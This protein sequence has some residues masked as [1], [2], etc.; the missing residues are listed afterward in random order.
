MISQ[1]KLLQHPRTS[2]FPVNLENMTTFT[3]YLGYNEKNRAFKTQK[4]F[5]LLG[6]SAYR[7]F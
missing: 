7:P 1:E 3:N 5:G 2:T 6:G 4:R